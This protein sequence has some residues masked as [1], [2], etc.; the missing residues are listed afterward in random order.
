MLLIAFRQI[1]RP[2]ELGTLLAVVR[3]RIDESPAGLCAR[4]FLAEIT[5]GPFGLPPD[6]VKANA[7]EIIDIVETHAY[8]PHRAR[9]LDAVLMGVSGPVTTSIVQECLDRWTLLVTQPS[10]ELIAQIA[11]NTTRLS[12]IGRGFPAVGLRHTQCR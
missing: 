10:R 3:D 9:L 5:F 4:E 11:P 2:S 8:G 6:S 1:S 12:A 7:S